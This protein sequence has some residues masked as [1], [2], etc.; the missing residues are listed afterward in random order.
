VDAIQGLGVLPMD[1]RQTPIDGLSAD[2]HKWL[3]APEGAGLFYL[4]REW[5]E[6]LHPVGVGWNSVVGAR[7]FSKIE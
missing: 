5:V 6:R 4:R 3:L 2:G 7:D 1:V